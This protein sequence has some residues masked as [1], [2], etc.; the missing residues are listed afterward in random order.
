MQV[1]FAPLRALLVFSDFIFDKRTRIKS[2]LT[3][4]F[5]GVSSGKPVGV[6]LAGKGL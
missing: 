1:L 6:P 3:L 2:S 5:P 4:R